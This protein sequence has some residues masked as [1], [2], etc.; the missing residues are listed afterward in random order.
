LPEITCV[1][2]SRFLVTTIVEDMNYY[3][4]S[5]DAHNP[6]IAREMYSTDLR[7]LVLPG[8]RD[9]DDPVAAVSQRQKTSRIQCEGLSVKI[10]DVLK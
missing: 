1:T 10:A 5:F 2:K 9:Y 3:D 8:I 4:K 7:Y 6:V